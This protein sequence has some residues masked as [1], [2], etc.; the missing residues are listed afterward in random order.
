MATDS[1]DDRTAQHAQA[2]HR[3]RDG[4]TLRLLGGFFSILAVLVLIG[5]LWALDRPHAMIVNLAAG[6]VLLAV[7]GGMFWSGSRARRSGEQ[8]A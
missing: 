1:T 5:T 7:G 6:M 3:Q 4:A 2:A 8:Q